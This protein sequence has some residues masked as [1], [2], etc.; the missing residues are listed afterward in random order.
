MTRSL[1]SYF[2]ELGALLRVLAAVSA[3]IGQARFQLF[4]AALSASFRTSEEPYLQKSILN[5]SR[6]R[7]LLLG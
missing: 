5:Y 2:C 1:T 3:G 7:P 4:A 6:T